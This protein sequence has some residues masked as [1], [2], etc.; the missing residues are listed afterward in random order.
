MTRSAQFCSC[1]LNNLADQLNELVIHVTYV[2]F[3]QRVILRFHFLHFTLAIGPSNIGWGLVDAN[4]EWC[5]IPYE[6]C[7]YYL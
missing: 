4:L 7:L 6:L 1:L 3:V 2:N 5:E